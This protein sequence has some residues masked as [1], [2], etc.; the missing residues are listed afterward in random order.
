MSACLSSSTAGAVAHP[1]TTPDRVEAVPADL[2]AALAAVPDPRARRGVRHR[3]VTVLAVAVCAVLAGA[4][5]YVAIAE[6]A[7]DLPV[8]VRVRLG[9]GRRAPSETTIRRVLQAIDAEALDRAVSSWLAARAGTAAAAGAA[10]A[11]WAGM[12]AIAVDGK[13]ARGARGIDGR[14]VHLLA[15]FDQATGV[16]LG[17]SVV[18]GKTNEI[19][20]FAPLLDRVDLAGVLITADALHTQ[21]RHAIYLHERGGHYLLTVK[22]NQP[23]LHTQLSAL[24]WTRIPAVDDTHDAGHGRIE[25][26]T[27]KLSAITTGIEF[28]YAR[29]ALQIIRRR[30]TPGSRRWLTET[31]YAITDLSWHQIRADQLADAARGHWG[32]E[33]KLHWVRDVTFA[34]DHSQ[35]R[36][37]AGPA[38]MAT[39]RNLAV[40]IH[41]LAGA[42]NIAA[43]CRHV[44]RHPNRILPLLE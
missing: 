39:L 6:W 42:T 18:D 31:V 28:P 21:H 44:S 33:N 12:R 29:L 1:G 38:A 35:I 26:R 27:I 25:S 11:S 17:Q 14:P 20:A 41:R 36:T 8:G 4:R 40:S 16:V 24:P 19:N 5:S 23:R 15:A 7:T 3:V 43:A 22:R 34:E 9:L 2:L 32:V 37:G 30:R 13:S 10:E